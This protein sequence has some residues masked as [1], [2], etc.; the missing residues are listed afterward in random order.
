MFFQNALDAGL[1]DF[2]SPNTL[3]AGLYVLRSRH[4][5]GGYDASLYNTP[6]P[7]FLLL[8]FRL[9]ACLPVWTLSLLTAHSPVN[10]DV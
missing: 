2:F 4:T 5:E 3:N 9:P 6:L 7:C 8:S 10:S 1:I